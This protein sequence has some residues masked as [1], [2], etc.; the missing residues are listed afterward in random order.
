MNLSSAT[1]T[2]LPNTRAYSFGRTAKRVLVGLLILESLALLVVGQRAMSYRYLPHIWVIT[3]AV[4]LAALV[5]LDNALGAPVARKT[6]TFSLPDV[7]LGRRNWI[8]L[9]ATIPM[10]WYIWNVQH[11]PARASYWDI[12]ALWCV[13]MAMSLFAVAWPVT[14]PNWT[15]WRARL[16]SHWQEIL[17]VSGI[18]AIAFI[19]RIY[20]LA[21]YPEIFSG[22]EGLFA[23]TAREVVMGKIR[24]PFDTT[25]DA[26]VSA[27][28][29][30]QAGMMKIFGEGIVGARIFETFVGTATI[31]I[32]YLL[33]RRNFGKT[34][35]IVGAAILA[36][37]HFHLY[38]S[39]D[40]LNNVSATFF[41]ALTL[42]LLDQLLETWSPVKAVQL[43][44]VIG[45][46]Q[47]GYISNRLLVPIA[48][49]VFVGTLILH[50]PRKRDVWLAAGQSL[51]LLFVGITVAFWP[52]AAY[53]SIHPGNF[54]ARLNAVSIFGSGWL[55]LE[56]SITG[57]GPIYILWHHFLDAALV[58]IRTNPSGYYQI[59]PP[60]IG[61]PLV[62]PAALGVA[63][64]TLGCFRRRYLP[65]A[66]SY[67][68]V[69]VGLG[70][71][72]SGPETNR[73]AAGAL[74]LPLVATVGVMSVAR[75]CRSFLAVPRVIVAIGLAVLITVI[76]VWNV[77][78]AFYKDLAV[79][80]RPDLNS[81]AINEFAHD[82]R[83]RG[84][85]YT[86]YFGA[87]P[88]MFYGGR[89]MLHYLAPDAVGIDVLEPWTFDEPAPVLTG[90]TL[91]FFLPERRT[92]VD[93]VQV[94]FPGG[95]LNDYRD[96]KGELL[97]T[98]YVIG[99]PPLAP[100][101]PQE[102]GS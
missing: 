61:W 93:V 13:M 85:G 75:M 70:M 82:L 94:W 51:L 90:P 86:V 65:I 20:E 54:N 49:A 22:D 28:V 87:P 99:A 10:G 40:A 60:F 68:V 89:P 27:W 14:L 41:L 53:F 43:G 77:R 92:E 18:T 100:Y 101:L 58:P 98:T 19:L 33:I 11:Q 96:D 50:H 2:I 78:V 97:Y 83:A 17:I 35:A 64:V 47:Y 55:E 46:A 25:F 5:L 59:E 38:M 24:N 12:V 31:P 16:Q 74:L 76:G 3:W 102:S 66:I 48:L 52:M 67:W 21:D 79:Y 34:A 1:R 23:R 62:I 29:F 73:Y 44:L 32:F 36:T 8:L 91:F 57:K 71:T 63:I 6:G 45:L 69:M 7:L 37:F 39:R 30:L 81:L 15:T 26:Q 72:V 56:E 4:G 80:R 88:S 95:Q 9:A 42:L 84:P